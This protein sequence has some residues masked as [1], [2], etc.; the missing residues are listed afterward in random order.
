MLSGYKTY[1]VAGIG[2]LL[3]CLHLAGID[4]P[5]VSASAYDIGGAIAALLAVITGRVGARSDAA[6]AAFIASPTVTS[7]DAA[8]SAINATSSKD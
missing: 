6:K 1:I 4:V 5:G 3:A 7:V 8:K 2:L